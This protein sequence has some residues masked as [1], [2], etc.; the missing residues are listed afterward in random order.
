MADRMV[1]VALQQSLKLT[2]L[3]WVNGLA[4]REHQKTKCLLSANSDSMI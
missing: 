1:T 4:T 2:A 3:T